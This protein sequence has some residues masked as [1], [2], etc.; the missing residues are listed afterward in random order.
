LNDELA[1][2]RSDAE[3]EVFET[4]RGDTEDHPGHGGDYAGS[5]NGEPEG[6]TQLG[7][8]DRRGVRPYPEKGPVTQGDLTRIA[9]ED[10]EADGGNGGYPDV[11]DDI[12]HVGTGE[13]RYNAQEDGQTD[14]EPHPAEVRAKDGDLLFVAL[15]KVAAWSEYQPAHFLTYSFKKTGKINN[16]PIPPFIIGGRGNLMRNLLLLFFLRGEDCF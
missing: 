3:V 9:D 1:C 15:F 2:Q 14:P 6:K 13:K 4:D 7:S 10:I 11:V 12:E 16:L 5:K 8:Q